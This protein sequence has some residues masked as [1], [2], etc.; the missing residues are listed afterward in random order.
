MGQKFDFDRI[1]KRM[2]YSVPPETF[3]E[4]D[5]AVMAAL[6]KDKVRAANMRRYRWTAVAGI[7]ATLFVALL[8]VFKPGNSFDNEALEQIDNAFAS[9]SEADREYIAEI[10]NEDI[11]I[12]QEF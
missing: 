11:F 4:I 12:N 7:A 8:L 6:A 5:T 10:Y 2:P 1:Q 9:L 3:C